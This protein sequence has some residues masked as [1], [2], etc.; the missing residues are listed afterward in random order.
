MP[1]EAESNRR[2]ETRPVVMGRKWLLVLIGVLALLS[3]AVLAIAIGVLYTTAIE[4]ERHR[5]EE[6][7]KSQA[8][9]MEAVAR[10][11]VARNPDFPGGP[12]TAT[13]AQV[14]DAHAHYPGFGESG[15]I[16]LGRR[17]GD[18]IVFLLSRERHGDVPPVPIA[19]DS[20]WGAPMRRALL[21]ETGSVIGFDYRGKQV[22]AAYTHLAGLN[23]GVVAK[24]DMDEIRAPYLRA[25]V[26]AGASTL[27][28]VVLGAGL[29]IVLSG[30]IFGRLRESEAHMRAIVETAV[31]GIVTIDEKGVIQSFNPAAERIFGY[32]AAEAVGRNVSRLMPEPDRSGHDAHLGRYLRTGEAKIIGIG[33]E[34]VGRRKDGES[35][36]VDLA[37]SEVRMAGRRMFV[38]ILRDITERRQ[39]EED[40]HR[41]EQQLLQSQ[42]MEAVGRLAGGLA[43]DFNN[44]LTTI[45][46]YSE[47]LLDRLE[48]DS[49]LRRYVS[50]IK[51]DGDR[52]ASLTRQLLSFSRAQPTQVQVLDLNEVIMS[53]ERML[54]RLVGDDVEFRL[55]LASNTGRVAAD[56]VQLEQV[57]MN[58][59]VNARDAMPR[60]GSLSLS[61]S[62]EVLGGDRPAQLHGLASG[63]YVRLSVVDT[64]IGM[65]EETLSRAFEPFFTTKGQGKGTGLGLSTVYGIVQQAGGTVF[66]ESE[67]EQGSTFTLYLPRVEDAEVEAAPVA[68]VSTPGPRGGAETILLV[69]DEERVRVLTEEVLRAS[70]YRVMAA[71]T[72]NEAL[73]ICRNEKAGIQ[74]LLTDVIML[75]MSGPA[76][77]AEVKGI[78]PGI[79]VLYMSGYTGEMI[80][81]HGY[82]IDAGLFIAKPFSPAVLTRRV[83]EILDAPGAA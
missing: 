69:E 71:A 58:L 44:Q 10:F 62:G 68:K 20:D 30:P 56:R 4:Q 73:E 70:G 65:D 48:A 67:P 35:F 49:P 61:T 23:L 79:R 22:L 8:R 13:M 31:D 45:L 47:M 1:P 78:R 24:V 60:G 82:R 28:L 50:E 74:L 29:I 77:A 83:R 11:N 43:H 15:E 40:Q 12:L 26:V 66:A 39:R 34:V 63:P 53:A 32:T 55:R 7:V 76:L 64:G 14:V 36:P 37:I 5:L 38:G 46:G 9:L 81:Q 33:R 18:L 59:V 51:E 52:A 21:G 54:R 17:E 3:L 27:Y 80:Q 72:P 41:L 57:L 6:I 2:D 75:Q 42:K 16:V 19:F 25:G